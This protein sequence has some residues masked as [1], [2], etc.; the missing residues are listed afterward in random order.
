M[1][2]CLKFAATV[3]LAFTFLAA[4]VREVMADDGY[5]FTVH[6]TTKVAIKKLLAS[7]DGKEYGNF[8]IGSGIAP[9]KEVTLKWD[10]STDEKGCTWFF[11]AMFA[12]G[13]ESEAKKFDFCEENVELEF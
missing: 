4:P 13:E 1:K 8:D 12:D 5:S 11:K 3:G 10:K 9:G 6:N 7:E 2:I